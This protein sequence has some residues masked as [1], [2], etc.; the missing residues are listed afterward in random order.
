MAAFT[1]R[2][3]ESD[4]LSR[5]IDVDEAGDAVEAVELATEHLLSIGDAG[6]DFGLGPWSRN[7]IDAAEISVWPA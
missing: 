3:A 5:V 2:F 6:A 4:G 7:R 1:V